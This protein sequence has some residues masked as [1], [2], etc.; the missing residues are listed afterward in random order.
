[1][2]KADGQTHREE[3]VA[4]RRVPLKY[5]DVIEQVGGN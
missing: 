4:D 1:M 2:E 3:S 5:Y